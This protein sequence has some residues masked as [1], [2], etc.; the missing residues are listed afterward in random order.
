MHLIMKN[1]FLLIALI[2]SV[3]TFSQ[4]SAGFFLDDL[5][6]KTAVK[7]AY[8]ESAKP[9]AAITAT[10]IINVADKITPISKY[11]FGNNANPYMTQMV[12]QPAQPDALA[13]RRRPSNVDRGNGHQWL[14]RI[15]RTSETR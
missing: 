9:D 6:L 15:P 8:V 1:F 5:Q 13:T 11:L 2:F 10:V 14:P 4:T 12:D 7:P 3:K